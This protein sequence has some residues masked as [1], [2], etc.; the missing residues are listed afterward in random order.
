M[1]HKGID[2]DEA[3]KRM[4]VA[5]GKGFRKNGFSGIGVDGLAKSAGMTS[6]A[7]YSH[8]GS[9]DKAFDIALSEGL[10]EV[11]SGIPKFQRQYQDDWVNVFADYYLSK[12]HRLDLECGCAMASLT[13]EVIRFGDN[14]HT[15]YEAKMTQ[16]VALIANGL[17]GGSEKERVDRAW[18]MLG[19]LIGGVNIARAMKTLALSDEI[20]SSIKSSAI[21]VAGPVRKQ[22]K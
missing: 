21:K 11:I 16:I 4:V 7:F 22:Y 15:T 3:R 10:D 6:G 14:I 5:I 9:K 18:S 2:K 12:S 1:R 20:S 8:F 13:P 19:I 17:V